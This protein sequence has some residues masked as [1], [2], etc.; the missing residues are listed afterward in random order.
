LGVGLVGLLEYRNSSF[1]READVVRLLSLPVLALVPAM[2]SDH[3]RQ[4]RRRR[5]LLFD[6][7]AILA[8]V[9]SAAIVISW[10]LRS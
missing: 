6:T 5:S 4:Q 7:A 2:A 1:E 3:E 8:L 10:G 9:G